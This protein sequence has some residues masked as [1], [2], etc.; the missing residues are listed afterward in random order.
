MLHSSCRE[1]RAKR[2]VDKQ[3][4]HTLSLPSERSGKASPLDKEGEKK[5]KFALLFSRMAT[6]LFLRHFFRTLSCGFRSDFETP[7]SYAYEILIHIKN[8]QF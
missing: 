1:R 5:E 2:C 8:S 4:T 7:D 3:T 6:V